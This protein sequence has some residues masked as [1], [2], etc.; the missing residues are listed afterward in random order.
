MSTS[1]PA[2]PPLLPRLLTLARKPRF[3]LPLLAVTTLAFLGLVAHPNSP[4]Q[5]TSSRAGAYPPSYPDRVRGGF[6]YESGSVGDGV[7][8][9]GTV[10]NGRRKANA[11][12]R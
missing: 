6:D 2:Q 8:R 7:V 3:F 9:N 10:V 1:S 11:V 12:S 5:L 4:Y